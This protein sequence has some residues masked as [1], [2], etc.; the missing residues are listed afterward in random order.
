MFSEVNTQAVLAYKFPNMSL[1]LKRVLLV[2]KS[3]FSGGK[4][5]PGI[6]AQL[7]GATCDAVL[8][9]PGCLEPSHKAPHTSNLSKKKVDVLIQ[10]FAC[11]V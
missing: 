7:R 2:R 4:Y 5:G 9:W 3:P 8:E 1:N 11:V 10:S 6:I